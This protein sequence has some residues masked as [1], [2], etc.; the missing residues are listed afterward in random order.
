MA[1]QSECLANLLGA[2]WHTMGRHKETWNRKA[3]NIGITLPRVV[4]QSAPRGRME[5]NETRFMTTPLAA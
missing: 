4:Q 5:R 2:Q 3:A 1:Q